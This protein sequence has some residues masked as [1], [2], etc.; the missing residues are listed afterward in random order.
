MA[1]FR[2]ERWH[3][4]L[5]EAL[6]HQSPEWRRQ[7]VAALQ[8]AA[9]RQEIVIYSDAKTAHAVAI[10]LLPWLLTSAQSFY[11]QALGN[12]I[13]RV[14]NRVLRTYLDDPALQEVL[15]FS[16]DERAWLARLT[17]QG[18]PDPPTVFERFDT[19]LVADEPDWART[20]R[21]LEFN[22]VGIGCL[23]FMP[24]ANALVADHVLPALQAAVPEPPL[25]PTSDPRLLLRG[26]LEA[27]AKAIGRS[28]CV[29]AFVERR[30]TSPG[31]ADEMLHVSRFLKTQGLQTICVDPRE[32]QVQ[33]GEIVHH[34][35]TIDML[36]RDFSLNEIISIDKHGGQVDAIQHAFQRNQVVSGLTGEFD[37]KSLC[38]LLSNPE[39]DRYFTPSQ[40]RTNRT[41][42]P[43][44]RLIRERKTPGPLGHEV[45]LPGFIRDHREGLVIKPNR[46]YG[47]QDVLIG[48]DAAASAWDQLL[49][50]A[51]SEP[52]GWVV[53]EVAPLPMADFLDPDDLTRVT[54]EFVT[55]GFIATSQGVAFVGRASPEPIVNISR[56]GRLVP[57]F[58]IR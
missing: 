42:I 26:V 19:N 18:F 14:L 21:I 13:R 38:E 46:A 16:E 8:E 29:V 36:Y 15:P 37:H 55:I 53:Q 41:V 45:E 54:H 24:V 1:R 12:R 11:I 40:R 4:K 25:R 57:M 33:G 35:L 52:N 23:H 5:L 28:R 44:T 17:P 6:R 9:H 30:E 10:H 50:K 49:A 7:T 2:R 32:L 3:A 51:L 47:G 27:H 43:W 39:F 58:L 34:D 48:K 56:G 31:G 22:A 20:L